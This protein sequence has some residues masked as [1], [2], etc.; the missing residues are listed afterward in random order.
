VSSP[1]ESRLSAVVIAQDEAGRLP[2][3]LDSLRFCDELLV[4]DGGSRD[5][6]AALA[7]AAGARVLER[8]F[9]DFA[10]QREFG[11]SQA[12]G[13]W[14]LSLDADERASPPLAQAARAIADRPIGPSTPAAFSL[15]FQNRFRGQWLRRGGL[16]PD[17]H[18]RLYQRQR[19]SYPADRPVHER[20]LVDGP[21][22][23]LD[24]PV[25]HESWRSLAHCLEKSAA[26][27]ERAAHRLHARGLRAGPADVVLRPLW[28]FLRAYL[29][30]LGFLDGGPG[31]AVAAGRA[32]EAYVRYARLWELGRYPSA[33]GDRVR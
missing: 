7:R 14:V 9:D 2:A 27:G 13:H 31:V 29:L 17:R 11:R 21:T 26:Y 24:A 4:V 33:A 30:Q 5:G 32:Y 18:V 1:G 10:R 15:P 16:W 23:R 20:L 19:C 25:I 6:T 3:C 12:R 8:P 22:G 28:R